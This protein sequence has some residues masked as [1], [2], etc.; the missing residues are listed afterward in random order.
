MFMVTEYA[1]LNIPFNKTVS[2]LVCGLTSQSA[3]QSVFPKQAM[4]KVYIYTE[5]L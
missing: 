2:I 4:T 5:G 3:R 1:A